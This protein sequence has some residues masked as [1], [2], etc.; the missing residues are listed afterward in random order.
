[1]LFYLIY[2]SIVNLIF[3]ISRSL[4]YKFYTYFY[5]L[6]FAYNLSDELEFSESS[7]KFSKIIE[8]F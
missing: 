6:R 5:I 1:M 4:N 7:S 8:S 2:S 3:L